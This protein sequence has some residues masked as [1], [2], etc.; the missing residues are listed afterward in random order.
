M[1]S[2]AVD[3]G[4]TYYFTLTDYA[5]LGL[6][7]ACDPTDFDGAVDAFAECMDSGQP[8]QVFRVELGDDAHAPMM[9]DVTTDALK[10]VSKRIKLRRMDAPEWLAGV[11]A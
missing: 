4:R 9:I 10:C 5:N 3:M 2:G 1:P 7:H 11:A 8:S 6:G